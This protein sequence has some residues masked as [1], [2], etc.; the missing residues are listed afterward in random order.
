[1]DNASEVSP[2]WAEDD[3]IMFDEKKIFAYK[4]GMVSVVKLQLL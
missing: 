3:S 2:W 1:M 4:F